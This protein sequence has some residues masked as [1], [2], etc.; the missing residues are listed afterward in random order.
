VVTRSP[1]GSV[2]VRTG[3]GFDSDGSLVPGPAIDEL[4]ALIEP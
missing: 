3:V 2:D 4:S 1:D